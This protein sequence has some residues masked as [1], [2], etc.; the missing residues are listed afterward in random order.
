VVIQGGDFTFK[1]TGSTLIFDGFLKVY[2]ADEEEKRTR[3][4]LSK[5]WPQLA[6]SGW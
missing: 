2:K 1:V 6:R 4:H 5:L 3:H